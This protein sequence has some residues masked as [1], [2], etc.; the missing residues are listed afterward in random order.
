MKQARREV[1]RAKRVALV[2]WSEELGGPEGKE[3]MFRIVKQ[4]KK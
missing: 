3:K 4:M 2:R 1:A